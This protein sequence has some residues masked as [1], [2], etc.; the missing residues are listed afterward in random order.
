MKLKLLLL[1]CSAFG[2]IVS[3]AV[4]ARADLSSKQAKT[5]ITKAA[6]MSLPSS[7]VH[8]GHIEM[9]GTDAAEAVADVDLVFRLTRKQSGWRIT[10]LRV[11]PNQWEDLSLIARALGTEVPAG[12]C[13]ANQ[14]ARETSGISLKR[15]RCL[16]AAL[17]GIE[18]PSD[19]VRIKSLSSF[20]MPLVSEESVLIVSQVRLGIRFSREAKGWHVSQ[21]KS[22]GRSWSSI[23]NIPDAVAGVKRLKATED[24]K[25]LAEALE[26]FR[27]ERGSF[28][29]T[30]QHP[31]LIDHLSP[32]YL[33]HVIRL[34]PWHNPYHYQGE[35]A[36]FTLRS[37]GP[38]GKPNTGDDVVLSRP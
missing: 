15:A 13:Y 34:D 12:S 3:S 23:E 36:H 25:A 8:I 1:I 6:G 4:T 21:I 22:G 18:L 17:F 33:T 5:L 2:L 7:A 27:R 29:V 11:A 20:G 16:V 26:L 19:A 10:E 31:A 28:V 24:M 37:A 14:F 32:R 30:D 9:S 35:Q 38:D